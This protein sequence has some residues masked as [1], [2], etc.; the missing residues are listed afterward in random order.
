[1]LSV[2]SRLSLS[3]ITACTVPTTTPA[4]VA[5]TCVTFSATLLEASPIVVARCFMVFIIRLALAGAFFALAIIFFPAVW[6]FFMRLDI[7]LFLLVGV[8]FALLFFTDFFVG[9]FF[10]DFL[11]DFLE[12]LPLIDF[13]DFFLAM[14]I[15]PWV[16]WG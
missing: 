9:T 8:R 5:A 16:T 11:E 14:R 2:D 1:V 4:A 10:D 12:D 6:T 13:F 7:A 3:G 15:S